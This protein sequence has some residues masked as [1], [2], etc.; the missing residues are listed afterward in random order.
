MNAI[1]GFA[2][3]LELD[4]GLTDNQK[5][6]LNEIAKAGHHLLELINE[7]LDLA[8]IEAGRLSVAAEAVELGEVFTDCLHLITPMAEQQQVTLNIDL[9]DCGKHVVMADKTRLKQI[10]LN[11][12]SNAIKYNRPSGTVTIQCQVSDDDYLR[13]KV[14]DTGY[15]MDEKAQANIFSAFNRL[16]A[17]STAVEGTGIGLV[18][19]KNL[20]ELMHGTIGF[21]SQQDQGTSFWVDL[22]MAAVPATKRYAHDADTD[23]FGLDGLGNQL[24]S[25]VYIEDNIPNIHLVEGLFS[26]YKNL[27]LQTANDGASGINLCEKIIPDL[28]LLDLN[29]PDISGFKVHEK[30]KKIRNLRDIPVVAVSANAMEN[31]IEKA[32]A[33]GFDAYLVKP[34]DLDSMLATIQRL[35]TNQQTNTQIAGK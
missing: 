18:I 3:L 2:Q 19:T 6:S 28:I 10:I 4:E 1:L 29:L 25:I 11:L 31:N 20:V 21:E 32:Q 23:A 22:P 15:G 7:V 34:V 14:T 12:C 30:L 16:G 8:K 27:R 24:F 33:A 17:E 35:L 26:K 13:I 9:D 5:R